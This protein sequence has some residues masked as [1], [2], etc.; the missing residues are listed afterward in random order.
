MR[1]LDKIKSN[2]SMHLV[3]KTNLSALDVRDRVLEHVGSLSYSDSD[4]F[5]KKLHGK[6]YE[7]AVTDEFFDFIRNDRMRG[8]VRMIKFLGK[9]I[10]NENI[11]EVNVVVRPNYSVLSVLIFFFCFSVIVSV[12]IPISIYIQTKE[13]HFVLILPFVFPFIMWKALGVVKTNVL[14]AKVFLDKLFDSK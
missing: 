6:I 7:G 14:N 12:A 3:Y 2:F 13:F 9:I 10:Q 11:S 8:D 4:D 5:G 1:L